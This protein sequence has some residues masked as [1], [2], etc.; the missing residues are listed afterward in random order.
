MGNIYSKKKRGIFSKE[1]ITKFSVLKF[2]D[3]LAEEIPEIKKRDLFI[4]NAKNF[5]INL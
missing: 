5:L 2:I 3:S 1:S 4:E